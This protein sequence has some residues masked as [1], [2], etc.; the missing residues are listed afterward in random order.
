MYLDPGSAGLFIQAL[1]AFFA[2]IFATFGRARTWLV[3]VLSK[4][5]AGIRGLTSRNPKDP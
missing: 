1:F 3:A 5:V 4:A 2:M